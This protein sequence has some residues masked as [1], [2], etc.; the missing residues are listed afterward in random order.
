LIWR[1]ISR[2]LS[3]GGAVA[4]VARRAGRCRRLD[5]PDIVRD[6]FNAAN[7]EGSRA[8]AIA[9]GTS[10][11]RR[12]KQV[13]RRLVDRESRT[14]SA[15]VFTDPEI[16]AREQRTVFR[17]CWL[18]VGHRSQFA[19]SGDFVQA[20]AGVLPLL[21]CLT[22][23]GRYHALANVCTHRGSRICQV[24]Q[25][26]AEKFVCPYHN[27]V[28]NNRGDLIGVPRHTSHDF[29]KSDWG[30]H[31]AARVAT[32]GDLIFATFSDRAPPLDEYLGDFRFYLDLLLNRNG[33]GTEVSAGVHRSRIHCNWKI[34]AEQFGADNWHFQSVHGSIAR[35]GGRN[36]N[37]NEQ[38]SFHAWT[39]QGHILISVA[40]RTTVPTPY[41]S[42]LDEQVARGVLSPPQRRLLRCTIVL[43][44]FP[45]L[46]IVYFP[47]MCSLR[48]W[49]PR[50]AGETELWSWALYN[51]D[52]PEPL[53]ASIRT[54][55]TRLFSPTGML[56]QD[57]LEVWAR[58]GTNLAAMPPS[59]RLCYA[60]DA[61]DKGPPRDHPGNLAPLQSDRAAFA[62]YER[63]AEL[64]AA[65]AGGDA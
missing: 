56:E 59:F 5:A 19:A 17:D 6:T 64:V 61:E 35:L 41:G 52:A 62:Y 43:T 3:A 30:L 24:E 14:V 27:W 54:Q 40:P 11:G 25:G 47:G 29:R 44:V 33:A 38:D 36:E 49:Q 12:E 21:L 28:F 2:A 50:A 55:V 20:G 10:P 4:P 15:R 60:F 63:W 16:F 26:H 65:G 42:Y 23:D 31:R 1:N 32:F 58:L 53:K 13:Q 7:R 57:D 8:R 9:V 48:V 18:Y 51:R 34:P 46:S 22:D 39:A 37:P 45:N